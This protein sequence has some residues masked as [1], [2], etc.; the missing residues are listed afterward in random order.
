MPIIRIDFD[1]QKL[2]DLDIKNLSKATQ[3]IVS[4]ET[5]IEDVFVYANS[6]K[7][8]YKIAPAEVFIEMSAHKIV[9]AD[10][11]MGRIK[12]RLSDWKKQNVFPQSINL[13]LIPMNWKVEIDI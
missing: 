13:T 7:F 8:S 6:P 12:T 9:D 3:K 11:L 2:S 4:E 10:E 1:S 5:G